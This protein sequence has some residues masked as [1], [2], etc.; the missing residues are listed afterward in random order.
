R[1]AR[2]EPWGRLAAPHH[3]GGGH[4]QGPTGGRRHTHRPR[5]HGRLAR[6]SL[7]RDYQ[8]PP[9]A[10]QQRG[11]PRPRRSVRMTSATV[12]TAATAAPPRR[13]LLR[14]LASETKFEFLKLLRLPVYSVATLAFP[15]MFYLIFG[16]FYGGFEAQGIAGSRYMMATFGAAGV[17]SAALFSF[18]VGVASERGQ[19]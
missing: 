14:L 17:L 9:P 8:P 5:G 11:G 16:T 2:R 19:G 10:R 12:A 3:P 6:G 15:L 18:G 1:H 13:N 4:G 7:P